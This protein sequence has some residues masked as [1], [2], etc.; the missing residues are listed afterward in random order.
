MADEVQT[1]GKK[2][3]KKLAAATAAKQI[4]TPEKPE[5]MQDEVAEEDELDPSE[6]ELGVGAREKV[7][8]GSRVPR[9]MCH[10]GWTLMVVCEEGG[11]GNGRDRGGRGHPCHRR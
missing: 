2:P 1:V 4:L 3:A 6:W 9:R 5:Q 10:R 11:A 7:L 8:P